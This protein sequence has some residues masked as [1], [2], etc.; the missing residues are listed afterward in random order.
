[1]GAWQQVAGVPAARLCLGQ[2]WLRGRLADPPLPDFRSPGP[3]AFTSVAAYHPPSWVDFSPPKAGA[4]QLSKKLKKNRNR[5]HSP[6]SEGSGIPVGPSGGTAQTWRPGL[7]CPD[8]LNKFVFLE[9][10]GEWLGWVSR[11]PTETAA[12]LDKCPASQLPALCPG[13]ATNHG[14]RSEAVGGS[15]GL[16]PVWSLCLSSPG[17]KPLTVVTSDLV[18]ACASFSFP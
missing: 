7:A 2:P 14:P 3:A 13:K 1:M 8:S 12:G 18:R 4:F 11:P 15:Q 17:N 5:S 16:C 9:P 10:E 6:L